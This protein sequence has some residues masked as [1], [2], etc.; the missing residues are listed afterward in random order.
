MTAA[1]TETLS[2]DVLVVGGGPAGST[3]SALLAGMGW[4]VTLLEKE[5]HPRFHIGE[6]LLPMNIPILE[7]LGVLEEVRRIGLVKHAAEFVSD[8]YPG[9]PQLFRF[10]KA[11]DKRYPYAFEVRRSEFDHLLLRNSAARGVDVREGMRVRDIEFRAAGSNRIRATDAAG[12]VQEWQA[13]FV[14]D[15]S[16]RD[17]LV[18]R[19]F[20]WKKKSRSHNSAAIFGH[21]DNVVRR[22]DE[23]EGNISIYWF[24]HGWFWM[25]PLRDGTMS[26]GA[27]CWPDYLKTRTGSLGA[28]LRETIRLCPG[29]HG[30]MLDATPAG[31]VRATGNFSYRST[32]LY[33]EDCLLVGDAAA[34]I[35]PVFSSGV[36]LAMHGACLG[37]D[38]I[39]GSLRNPAARARLMRSYQRTMRR[40][41]R[42]L[43]WFIYRFTSPA[44]HR[45]FM[46]PT[47]RFLLEP[48]VVSILAGDVFNRKR[49]RLPLLL[50]RILYYLFSLSQWRYSWSAYHRRRSGRKQVFSQETVL[51]DVES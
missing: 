1:R 50:F 32:R 15:A 42:T 48:A 43:S 40:G 16:G 7:R 35:D 24:A 6:S 37:A 36:Y 17:T 31:A 9:R 22:A 8:R 41:L 11:F 14:V 25:I 21:F 51:T 38:A 46:H 18:S 13:R 30:R 28:F 44:L 45:M 10:K 29:V 20:D 2:C 26:V 5:H 34:F 47:D 23:D 27:V 49:L 19:K 3:I 39:D 4:R 33:R 12:I